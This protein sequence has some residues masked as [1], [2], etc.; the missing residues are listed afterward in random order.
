MAAAVVVAAGKML[1]DERRSRQLRWRAGE[2]RTG[3]VWRQ[4]NSRRVGGAKE[5]SYSGPRACLYQSVC[6]DLV[7][8]LFLGRLAGWLE[9]VLTTS[10]TRLVCYVVQVLQTSRTKASYLQV[11][12]REHLFYLSVYLHLYYIPD[13][14]RRKNVGI[15]KHNNIYTRI[16]SAAQTHGF[17]LLLAATILPAANYSLLSP[18]CFS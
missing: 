1:E 5:F 18:P 6:P 16:Y 3:N 9:M 17:S 11:I 15:P 4:S 13:G 7:C 12:Q 2:D 14:A 8:I 10:I